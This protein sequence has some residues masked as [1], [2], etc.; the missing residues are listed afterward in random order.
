M[1]YDALGRVVSL[2]NT[3]A[4]QVERYQYTTEGL[5]TVVEVYQGSIAPQ[6]LLKIQYR[7][8]ND[9]RQLVSEHELVLE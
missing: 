1:L 7:I 9:I 2:G 5:R 6:N 4:N 3:K 8:Y